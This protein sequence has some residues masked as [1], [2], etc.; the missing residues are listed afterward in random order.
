ML[1]QTMEADVREIRTDLKACTAELRGE[2]RSGT[3]ELRSEIQS[4]TQ[5]LRGEI[6]GLRSSMESMQRNMLYGFMTL[7]GLIAGFQIF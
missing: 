2:I 3:Q 6:N 5:E 1:M 7:A 4:N